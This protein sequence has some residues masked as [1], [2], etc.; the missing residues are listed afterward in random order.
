M[1]NKNT[2]FFIFIKKSQ[3]S[4]KNYLILRPVNVVG[5][6][7]IVVDDDDFFGRL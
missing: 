6:S 7:G 1:L 4:L 3:P 5:D 2:F